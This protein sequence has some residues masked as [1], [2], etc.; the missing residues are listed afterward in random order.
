MQKK[1]HFK[2]STVLDWV[3]NIFEYLYSYFYCSNKRFLNIPKKPILSRL[4]LSECVPFHMAQRPH[5]HNYHPLGGWTQHTATSRKPSS[6][7]GGNTRPQ[8][9][10]ENPWKSGMP[11]KRRSHVC[12]TSYLPVIL[13]SYNATFQT[14]QTWDKLSKKW[15][16]VEQV[17]EYLYDLLLVQVLH[18]PK[19]L[20]WVRL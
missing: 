12:H 7:Q 11:W 13:T 17:L 6:A 2:G 19:T 3:L 18:Y 16:K 15:M 20:H 4:P 5:Q 10:K 14:Y 1:E 8:Q 9:T